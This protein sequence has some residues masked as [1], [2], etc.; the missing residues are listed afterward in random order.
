M[1]LVSTLRAGLLAAVALS[2]FAVSAHA[3]TDPMTPDIDGKYVARQGQLR[4]RKARRD[5]PDARRD[6]ALHRHRGPQGRQ[7]P[8]HPAD[9]H[10]L[11]RRQARGPQR[12]P[13]H[14]GGPAQGDEVFVADGGY[15][16]VFQDIRGK[17]GSE[18]DYVMTRPLKGPLNSVRGRPLH[19]RLRHHRLAGEECAGD[20]RQGRHA[21]QLLRGL[22]RRDGPGQSAPGPEGRRADEPDGRRLDGRRLVPPRRLPPAELRLLHRPDHQVAARATASSARAMTTTPTS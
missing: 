4:L 19:R 12:Q 22:H 10:A 14:G 11:Q 17:Y 1:S 21:G 16:R 13:A 15:I 5:D 8:A 3:Q 20:Q 7:E 6:Q 9:P 2:A 18:G